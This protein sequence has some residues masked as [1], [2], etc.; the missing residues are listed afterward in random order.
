MRA[1]AL[2]VLLTC[3]PAFAQDVPPA[4]VLQSGQVVTQ[5]GAA[6]T[7]E[8]GSAYLPPAR[9]LATAKELERLRAENASLKE[10][11]SAVPVWAWVAGGVVLGGA[12]VGLGVALWPKP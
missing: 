6:L 7:V 12:A 8:P 5:A 9:L 1:L 2:G 4:E 3:T 11:I 10:S